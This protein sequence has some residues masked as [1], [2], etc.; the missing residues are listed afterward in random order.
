[1]NIPTFVL[2]LMAVLTADAQAK[3]E[4]D[5]KSSFDLSA[6]Y[7]KFKAASGI[8]TTQQIIQSD[9]NAALTNNTS[10]TKLF[11]YAKKGDPSA[12]NYVGYLFE[13]G[14]GVKQDSVKAEKW[15]L[16][17]AKNNPKAAYNL[18]VIY[19]D[20]R[21][22]VL[23][24]KARAVPYLKKAWSELHLPLA[25]IRLAYWY[26]SQKDWQSEWDVLTTLEI[27]KKYPRHWGYLMGEMIIMKQAPIYDPTK[28]NNALSLA[29][30]K[31]NGQAAELL[32]YSLGTGLNGTVDTYHACITEVFAETFGGVSGT[33]RWRSGMSDSDVAACKGEAAIWLSKNKRPEPIDFQS[34]IY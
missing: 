27:G 29:V 7:S 28:A 24:D 33:A 26:R 20:G 18:G 5:A 23:Q 8:T 11:S 14:K 4:D 22:G 3:S 2:I 16:Y 19:S 17:C 31:Y 13:V 30:D 32:A 9:F 6:L 10:P 25:G 21:L 12:C 1:M 15:F 34:L